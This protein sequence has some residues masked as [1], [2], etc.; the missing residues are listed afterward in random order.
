[1]DV[2][3]GT[4]LRAHIERTGV[5]EDE[6]REEPTFES[7][8]DAARL[9]DIEQRE[10]ML[11]EAAAELAYRERRLLEREAALAAAAQKVSAEVVARLLEVEPAVEDELERARARRR[12]NVA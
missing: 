9:M 7:A 1:M 4:G 11:V 5:P 10:R 2:E 12:G 3:F 6:P 8:V